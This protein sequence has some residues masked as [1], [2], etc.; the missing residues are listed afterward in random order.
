M[1]LRIDDTIIVWLLRGR[2]KDMGKLIRFLPLFWVALFVPLIVSAQDLGRIAYLEGDVQLIRDGRL[3][4]YRDLTIGTT[5][6]EMDVIQTGDDGYTEIELIQPAGATVRIRENTAYYVEVEQE[7]GGGTTTRLKVLSG[8]VEVAVQR[9]SRGSRLDVETRTAT[10]GVRGT[11]FDVI[12]TPDESS[13]LGVREGRV[14]ASAGQD[15]RTAEAGQ[16]VQS[17]PDQALR[18]E[19]VPGG[20]FD[21]YYTRWE[22]IR[23]EVFRSGASTFNQAYI[24]RYLDT[25]DNFRKS[26][27]DLKRHRPLLEEAT[28]NGGSTGSDIRLRQ[29]VSPAIISMRSILPLFENTVYRLR[30]LRRYHGEGIG[31]TNVGSISSEAF[32]ND[33]VREEASL[34]AQLT[35]VRTIFALYN[36]IER[37]SFGGLP[38]GGSPF[39]G[40]SPLDGAR[41][42]SPGESPFNR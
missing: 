30:E 24:R 21:A 11:R 18:Q 14:S 32:Y 39:G 41:P 22:E 9:M 37:R 15:Q 25:I 16:V 33:F 7:T 31:R 23:M 4:D 35:E 12:T 13:L 17:V 27:N 38:G 26:Y 29:E 8:T 10:F 2:N 28:R 34:I 19:T 42:F 20:D 6:L 5:I 36:Q 40:S 3:R 1:Y